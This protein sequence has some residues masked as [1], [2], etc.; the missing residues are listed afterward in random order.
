MKSSTYLAA[1]VRA[2]V[3]AN[4]PLAANELSALKQGVSVLAALRRLLV[5]AAQEPTGAMLK[6]ELERTRAVVAAVET[7]AHNL[8]RAAL[9]SWESGCD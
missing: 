6:D 5:R 3:T 7:C 1:L 2:H 8:A 9:T 4:P